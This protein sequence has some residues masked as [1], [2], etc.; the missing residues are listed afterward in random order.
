MLPWIMNIPGH[1]LSYC[2]HMSG[3]LTHWGLEKGHSSI[4]H[5]N[6]VSFLQLA[7]WPLTH[8]GQ[9]THI[10]ISKLTII[11]SNNGLSPGWHQAIILTNVGILLIGPLGTNL[12]KIFIKIHTFSFKKCIWKCLLEKGQP[13]CLSLNVLNSCLPLPIYENLNPMTV[14]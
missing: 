4:Y 11:G 3:K 5:Y 12:S 6:M 14:N 9:V 13:F 2:W 1:H 10:C 7:A 8:W